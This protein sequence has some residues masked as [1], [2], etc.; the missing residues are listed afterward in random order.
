[1]KTNVEYVHWCC[2]IVEA[3][4]QESSF[5]PSIA[6]RAGQAQDVRTLVLRT[7]YGAVGEKV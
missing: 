4:K 7:S 3:V 1:M 6:L 2:Y 5:D